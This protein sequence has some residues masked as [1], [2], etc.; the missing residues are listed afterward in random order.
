[1]CLCVCMSYKMPAKALPNTSIPTTAGVQIS[2]ELPGY[3]TPT[4]VCFPLRRA[5]LSAD[6]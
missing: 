4:A 6:C 1:M 2:R 3:P 5:T